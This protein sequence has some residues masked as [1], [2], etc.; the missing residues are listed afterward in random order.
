M[1]PH[2]VKIANVIVPV[3]D[4]DGAVEFYTERLGLEKRVEVPFG[5]GFRWIEVAPPG[6]DTTI[7]LCPPGPGVTAGG[8]Q[9]GISLHTSDVDAYHAELTARGVDV[10]AEVSRFGDA[11]PPTFWLRDHEGNVLQVTQTG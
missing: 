10:D 6:A 5:P 1:T 11:V 9:T 4:Q 8:K 7:A 2:V 3:A